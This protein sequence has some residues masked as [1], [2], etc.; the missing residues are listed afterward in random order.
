MSDVAYGLMLS[1]L[2][3]LST[4]VGS[5]VGLFW[6]NPGP[7][8]MTLTLGFSGG[9]MLHV[10][11]VEL[12]QSSVNDI[13]FGPAHT[14]F[15]FGMVLM[16][17]LHML[18]PHDYGAERRA[19]GARNGEGRLLQ[20]GIFVAVGLGLHNFPEGMA[21]FV[22]ALEDRALG[23]AIAVAIALH[24]IP[25]GLAVSAP[26]YAATRSRS[27]AFWWSFLSGVS[28]PLGAV[29]AAVVLLPVLNATILGYV[30]AMVAGVM[31]FIALDELVPISRTLGFEHLSIMGVVAGMLVMAVSLWMLL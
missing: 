22:G 17:L 21:A 8:M 5:L 6:T 15:F 30:L 9:V 25:E 24:N 14:A 26:I 23:A 3:G 13:G 27:K 1:A 18:I 20:S 29:V 10:S 11:Y 2:A 16:F 28:E 19:P 12:L 4:T 31:V 7:R